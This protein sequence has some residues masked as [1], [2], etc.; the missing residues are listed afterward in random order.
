MACSWESPWGCGHDRSFHFHLSQH[1]ILA[2]SSPLTL[3]TTLLS[4][5]SSN[6]LILQLYRVILTHSQHKF[7]LCISFLSSRSHPFCPGVQFIFG[8]GGVCFSPSPSEFIPSP[9][10][11]ISNLPYTFSLL[12]PNYL[13]FVL[14]MNPFKHCQLCLYSSQWKFTVLWLVILTFLMTNFYNHWKS[15]LWLL[16]HYIK[17]QSHRVLISCFRSLTAWNSTVNYCVWWRHW[18]HWELYVHLLNFIRI[19]DF[20]W[21][22]SVRLVCPLVYIYGFN[23]SLTEGQRFMVHVSC[24]SCSALWL[25]DIDTKY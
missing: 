19:I 13:L 1:L 18:N 5:S 8:W 17:K 7:H 22:S 24:S 12:S 9:L 15:L 4:L 23:D 11:E 16:R 6:A 20:V 10:L 25:Q 2:N 3:P 21:K 14:L